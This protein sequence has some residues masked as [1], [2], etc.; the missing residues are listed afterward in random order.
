MSDEKEGE[1]VKACIFILSLTIPH[2][3]RDEELAKRMAQEFE[4]ILEPYG[5][6]SSRWMWELNKS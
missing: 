1:P 3:K 5:E 6:V 2:D 4:E